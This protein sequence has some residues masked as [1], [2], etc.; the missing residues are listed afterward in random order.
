MTTIVPLPSPPARSQDPDIFIAKSDAFLAAMPAFGAQVN[1]VGV[2]AAAAAVAAASSQTSATAAVVAATQAAGVTI[3]VS[4]TT[5][6]IG[7]ARFSPISYQS[8]RRKTAG[9]GTTD[10]S[11]DGTNWVLLTQVGEAFGAV[12]TTATNLTLTTANL[13]HLVRV[14][15][16]GATIT[17]PALTSCPAGSV[18]SVAAEFAL[19]TVTLKGNGAELLGNQFGVTANTSTLNA[20]STIQYVSNGTSWVQFGSADSVGATGGGTD[21]AFYLN[22]QIISNNYT[23]PTGKNAMTAG[24][25]TIADGITVTV[26]DGSTW[27]IV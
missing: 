11:A 25:I 27:S 9:A 6:V 20:R 22:D 10:P 19:G 7:D 3:W 16:T 23:V 5:Y 1:A 4:G 26:S 18:I 15:A 2:E 24:P 8:Y 14:T 13:G 21:A 12:T 17:F